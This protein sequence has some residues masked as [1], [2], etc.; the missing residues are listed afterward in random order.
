M[1]YT[2]GANRFGTNNHNLFLVK[3]KTHCEVAEI[4]GL[5]REWPSIHVH[6]IYAMDINWYNLQKE[7]RVVFS[8]QTD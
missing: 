3:Y 5:A 1:S 8:R 6:L 4:C 2:L 7:W